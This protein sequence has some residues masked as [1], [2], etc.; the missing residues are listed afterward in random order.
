VSNNHGDIF[1][2]DYSDFSVRIA[3]LLHPREWCEVM[4]YSPDGKFL[5]V[6]AHDDTVYIYAVSPKGD[7]SLHI[8]FEYIHSS[9]ITALDWTLDSVHLRVIDQAYCKQFYDVQTCAQVDDD[10]C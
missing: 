9:A 4:K 5:A 2:Y 10:V 7:Y 3:T 8:K 6:G 1:V